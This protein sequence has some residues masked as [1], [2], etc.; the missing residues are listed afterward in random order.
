MHA[1]IRVVAA[2]N[3]DLMAAIKRGDFREDLYYRLGVFEITLPPLRERPEDILLLAEAFLEEIGRTVGRPAAGVSKDARDRLLTHPW[4]GNV[5]ELRNAIERAVIL[6]EGGLITGEHLPMAL[7]A[8]PRSPAPPPVSA[9]TPPT[10]IPPEGVKLEAIERELI[11][12]AMAQAQNNKSEAAR[13]LGLARG[14]LYSRLKRYGLTRA[15]R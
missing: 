15:R 10:A 2:T 6:C 1:D 11:Q 14:Q 5:R 7:A 3:R 13:L 4:P 12:K 8:A 9:V